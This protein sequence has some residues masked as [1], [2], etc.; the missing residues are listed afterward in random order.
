MQNKSSKTGS[1]RETTKKITNTH[2]KIKHFYSNYI[3]TVYKKK[4]K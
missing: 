2:L 4:K 1:S 3:S